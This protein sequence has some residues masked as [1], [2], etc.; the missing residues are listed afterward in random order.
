MTRPARRSSSS[1]MTHSF[2]RPPMT[3]ITSTPSAARPSA[4]GCTT[5]VPTPPPTHTARPWSSSS[6]ALPS[7]PATSAIA[8]PGRSAT[9]SSVLLPT[10]W[11][12]SV[13][14]PRTGSASAIVS[15]IRSAPGARWTMTN[16]PGW[17]IS[18]IRGALMTR[19]VTFGE[20]WAVSMTV[21]IGTP[22]RGGH[23]RRHH[24]PHAGIRSMRNGAWIEGPKVTSPPGRHRGKEGHPRRDPA[25]GAGGAEAW[26]ALATPRVS[27]G[28]RSERDRRRG[29]DDRLGRADL[30]A[31]AATRR[32][33]VRAHVGIDD[34]DLA[35][36]RDRPT[37]A[38][39]LAVPAADAVVGDR[40]CHV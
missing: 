12:T 2:D 23:V 18:A 35:R 14:V 13:I 37:W 28:A 10:A 1:K 9:R 11:I 33:A 31:H 7:G 17:R 20:S 6:V 34:V 30:H 26:L 16:W 24:A 27:G 8:S 22:E 39:R 38:L 36:F 15:G 3:L 19:R 40:A 21:C 5:A 4:I 32:D 29:G 25:P